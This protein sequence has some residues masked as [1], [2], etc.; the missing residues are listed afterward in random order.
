MSAVMHL[1][2]IRYCSL[3]VSVDRI[4]NCNANVTADL[5]HNIL[6]VHFVKS[7]LSKDILLF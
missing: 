4:F 6:K 7:V 5:D 1:F 2:L 3:R